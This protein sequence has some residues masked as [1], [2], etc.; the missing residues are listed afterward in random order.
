LK[1][2]WDFVPT[3]QLINEIRKLKKNVA[4]EIGLTSDEHLMKD[5]VY[6]VYT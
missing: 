3:R 6:V 4:E 1:Y 5:V 2:L